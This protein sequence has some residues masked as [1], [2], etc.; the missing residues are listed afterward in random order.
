[1]ERFF[2]AASRAS[3][4]FYRELSRAIEKHTNTVEDVV[5]K[6]MEQSISIWKEV[7]P[8]L[9]GSGFNVPG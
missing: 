2:A 4:I 7:K 3:R 9:S 6:A 5:K 8:G 1:M